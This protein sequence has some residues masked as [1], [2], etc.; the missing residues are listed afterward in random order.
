VVRVQLDEL[1][2]EVGLLEQQLERRERSVA[3]ERPPAT[4][5][6]VLLGWLLVGLTVAFGLVAF[7]PRR[8]PV[9]APDP[10]AIE[11]IDEPER[12]PVP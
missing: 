2:T 12:E 9:L 11:R 8:R 5:F 10:P 6:P 7:R 4:G 1:R 3:N